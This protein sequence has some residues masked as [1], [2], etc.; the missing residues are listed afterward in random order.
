MHYQILKWR[1]VSLVFIP[2]P[3]ASPAHLS[4]QCISK[5]SAALQLWSHHFGFFF[6]I[7]P[8]SF[9]FSF[10][11]SF[12][13]KQNKT[14]TSCRERKSSH[15][16]ARAASLHTSVAGTERCRQTLI[17]LCRPTKPKYLKAPYFT[18]SPQFVRKH[19]SSYLENLVMSRRAVGSALLSPSH[20]VLNVWKLSRSF[21]G[22]LF[23][24]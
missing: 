1:R 24:F 21:K 15:A 8:F 3:A 5:Q 20:S 19:P 23:L 4:P 6:W 9:K 12:T 11:G 10:C 14:K 18:F 2:T 22:F 13:E 7:C 16:A 17:N